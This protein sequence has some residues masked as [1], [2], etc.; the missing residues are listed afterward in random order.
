MSVQ[1]NYHFKP[2]VWSLSCDSIK[3]LKTPVSVMLAHGFNVTSNLHMP[4]LSFVD[5]G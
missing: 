2:Y 5:E 3:V 1:S 4:T